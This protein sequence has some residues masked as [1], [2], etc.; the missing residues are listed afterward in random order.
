MFKVK[1]FNEKYLS[2]YPIETNFKKC[3]QV[4]SNKILREINNFD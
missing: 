2:G 4:F 1:K 3:K